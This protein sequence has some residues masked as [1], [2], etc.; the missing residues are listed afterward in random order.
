MTIVLRRAASP[1]AEGSPSSPGWLGHRAALQHLQV[2]AQRASLVLAKAASLPCQ[3]WQQ[4][5]LLAV[6][7]AFQFNHFGTKGAAISHMLPPSLRRKRLRATLRDFMGSPAAGGQLPLEFPLQFPLHFSVWFPKQFSEHFPV[8]FPLWLQF[9]FQLPVHFSLWFLL[10]SPAGPEG[11][12]C[13]SIT[14][15]GFYLKA[16]GSGQSWEMKRTQWL[17]FFL[18]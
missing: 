15:R 6:P 18:M 7:A 8:Q 3:P 4:W 17:F 16:R 12:P 5:G 1:H 9:T 2:P 10:Q 14:E 13:W 11:W